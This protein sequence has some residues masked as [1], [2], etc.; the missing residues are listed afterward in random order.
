MEKVEGIFQYYKKRMDQTVD[1]VPVLFH[2]ILLPAQP[3]F[4]ERLLTNHPGNDRYASYSPDG[5]WIVFLT[6]MVWDI[7]LR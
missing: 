5:R 6:G 7:F 1:P 4:P 3:T 2:S